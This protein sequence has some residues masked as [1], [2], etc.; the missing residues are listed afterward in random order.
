MK[1]KICILFLLLFAEISFAQYPGAGG[2][3]GAGSG[4]GGSGNVRGVD[5]R[6][7]IN[8]GTLDFRGI[9]NIQRTFNGF[10]SELS[11]HLY[12]FERGR[13]RSNFFVASRVM[14]YTGQNVQAGETDDLQV[15]TVTPGLEVSYGM[16]HLQAG[17]QFMNV[18]SYFV[19]S[20]SSGKSF[21]VTAPVVAGHLNFRMGHLGLGVGIT[22]VDFAM[23]PEKLGLPAGT[24]SQWKEV[25]YSFNLI[26]F[27]GSPPSKFF[28]QLFK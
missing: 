12:M 10:G 14:S 17:Y 25:S 24:Q 5:F 2:G 23:D 15:F 7:Q 18:N 19:S 3:G 13:L 26:Y 22:Q 28:P 21:A 16:I 4:G 20:A 11:S 8:T 6:M 9:S 27:I 1:A